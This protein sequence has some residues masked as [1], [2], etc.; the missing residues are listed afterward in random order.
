MSKKSLT[1]WNNGKPQRTTIQYPGFTHPETSINKNHEDLTKLI[2]IFAENF[3][4]LDR[5]NAFS[6]VA[7]MQHR[8]E[9]THQ[10]WGAMATYTEE[11]VLDDE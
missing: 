10:I 2:I 4:E 5:V 6:S 9:W 7:T 1:V 8:E 3:K 11:N